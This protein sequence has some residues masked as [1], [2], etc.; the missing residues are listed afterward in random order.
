MRITLRKKN[1]AAETLSRE[2]GESGEILTGPGKPK[3]WDPG[4]VRWVGPVLL[5]D[6]GGSPGTESIPETGLDVSTAENGTVLDIRF[7]RA[8]AAEA[9]RIVEAVR[10]WRF[11]PARLEGR[12]VKARFSM[13]SRGGDPSP[14][15]VP[16]TPVE[17]GGEI[18][19]PGAAVPVPI[20]AGVP[21]PVKEPLLRLTVDE[22]GRVADVSVQASSGDGSVDRAATE[23]ARRLVFVPASKN[24]Q[25][26]AVYLNLPGRF[27]EPA[28]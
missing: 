14:S 24:G 13:S 8:D 5:R 20:P 15:Q 19:A 21:R 1:V 7:A 6:E 11:V 2:A 25:P 27:V 9:S 3:P 17:A 26:V 10:G 16:G 18:A 23:A 4:D 28:P 22:Q 12:P